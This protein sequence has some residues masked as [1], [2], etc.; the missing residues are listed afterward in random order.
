MW[1]PKVGF[2]SWDQTAKLHDVTCKAMHL[3]VVFY[4]CSLVGCLPFIFEGLQIAF[5]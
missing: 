4:H 2:D 5:V 1:H 3:R